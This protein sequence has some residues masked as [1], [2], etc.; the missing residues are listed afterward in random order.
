MKTIDNTFPTLLLFP[1]ILISTLSCG[2]LEK[3]AEP[4][5]V[6]MICIDDLNDWL[7]CMN[8]HPNAITPNIDR[9]AAGGVLFM[10]AHCQAPLCGPSRASVMTGLRPSTTGIY[11]MIDD[12]KIT[13]DN[14][15]TEEIIFLPQYFRNNGYHTMGIGKIFH[16]HAPDGAFDESGGRVRGFGPT[17]KERFVWSGRPGKEGYEGTSTD[18]GAYPAADS[19]MPDYQSVQWAIERLNREYKQ[20]FFL[21]VGFLRPHVPWYVPQKWFDLH[22]LE[23]IKEPPY[24]KEDLDDLP[25]IVREI[26]DLPMM[27]STEWAIESGEWPKMIQAY[28]ACISFVDHYVGELLDALEKSNHSDNTIILL[29]SDHGYRMGEKGTFAKHCL[30]EAGTKAPLIIAGPGIQ[31]NKKVESPAEML[32]I[33]PTLL[34]LCNLEPYAENEGISL[35]P[36][37]K[38]TDNSVQGYA[39]TTYGWGNHSIRTKNQRYIRY[40]DGSEEFY[41]HTNDPNEWYNLVSTGNTVNITKELRRFLPETDKPYAKHSYYNFNPYF[42]NDKIKHSQ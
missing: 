15:V 19:L 26:D 6:L 39:L 22:P 30:W 18:W 40:N 14:P 17:P 13:L 12:D 25:A 11:G 21:A 28:L 33:Y 4:P 2:N 24:F 32:S 10:N 31:K 5:N 1:A 7:G 8:G 38:G 41:D 34:E 3:E 35:V 29:W 27:P 20:P 36:V 16:Q 37:L 42:A 23:S 9:L